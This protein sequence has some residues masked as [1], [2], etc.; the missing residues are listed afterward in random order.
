[1]SSNIIVVSTVTG[2]N[3]GFALVFGFWESV[4]DGLNEVLEV[5]LLSENL[6]LLSKTTGSW[7][8]VSVWLFNRDDFLCEFNLK[9]VLVNPGIGVVVPIADLLRSEPKANLVVG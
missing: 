1:M 9:L 3:H 7:L 4:E 2:D 5:M 8:L 6:D